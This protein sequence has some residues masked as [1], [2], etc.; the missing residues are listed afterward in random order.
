[1]FR[2]ERKI[3]IYIYPNVGVG[4]YDEPWTVDGFVGGGGRGSGRE[5]WAIFQDGAPGGVDHA[6]VM[7]SQPGVSE[8]WRL[9]LIG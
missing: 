4:S 1:M 2:L 9:E 8:Q 7:A 5:I 3:H 6:P